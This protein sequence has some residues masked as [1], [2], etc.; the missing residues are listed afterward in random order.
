MS[1]LPP[2]REVRERLRTASGV[3]GRWGGWILG[4]VLS[5]GV[6]AADGEIRFSRDILPVLSDA[7]FACHGPDAQSR[8][9]G[10]RLDTAEGVRAPG[11]SGAVVVLP[12]DPGHSELI[13]RIVSQDPDEVMP[14]P[15]SNRRLTPAQ[16]D[17][18]RRWVAQGASWGRHWAYEVP[19]R[20]PVPRIRGGENPVDGFIRARL[21]AEGLAP[22]P[23]AS[24]EV[25]MRRVTLDLTGV[26][27]TPAERTAFLRDDVPGAYE[28]LVD[29]L[30]ASPR[31][32]ERM[33][34]E[35][36][37]A[38]RYA[39]SNGYQG[40]GERTMWPWRDWV[41]SALNR[42]QPYDEFTVWQLAGDLLPGATP[43]QRLATGFL[44]NHMINGEGGRIPEENRIDYL[45][46]QT[47]TVATVWLAATFNCTRCH[48]HKYDPHTQRDYFGLLA[49]FNRT[50][51]DGSGGN[52]Q[53]PPAL[54]VPSPEQ[55]RKRSEAL[56]DLAAATGVTEAY[57]DHRFPRAPGK[58]P[59]DSAAAAGLPETVMAALR[60]RAGD[61]DAG[62]LEVIAGHFRERD[63]EYAATLDRQRRA[64]EIRDA[65]IR[66]IPRVMVMEDVEKPRAT[67]V[68]NRGSYLQ[69]VSEVSLALPKAL[70]TNSAL[71]PSNR[72]AL[73]EWLVSP[74]NPLTA[75]VT[76]NRLWQALFGI[77]LVKTAE[78]F[79]VQGE[80]PLHPQLLDWLAVE[81]VESGWDVKHLV[82]LMVTSAAYRQDS[83]MS[84]A[85]AERDP[86]NRLLARGPRFRMPSWMIRDAALSVSGLLVERVGGPPVKP[87]QP[88]GIWEEA[89][90]G[91]KRYEQDHGEALYRRSLYVF[92]R[93]IVGPTMF[94][95][96]ASRQTCT[97]RTPRTN[98]P[99]HA[100]LTLNDLTYLEAARALA[101]EVLQATASSDGERIRSAFQRVTGRL[102]DDTEVGV[103]TRALARH[104]A[105]YRADPAAA[106]RLLSAG[107]S[108]RDP[109][110]DSQDQAAWMLLCS[111]ILNLDEALTRE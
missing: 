59:A 62:K 61:R 76:V 45:F 107:E 105:T 23:E 101:S 26:P 56:E 73:A 31:F 2:S 28:R 54:D 63:P 49:F 1:F 47:E 33:A 44:R 95:D 12:G 57:E 79:G 60:V 82:R 5:L 104:R 55:S 110:S 8:K 88:S 80:R 87:Y 36:L 99:L 64:R 20:P 51:V 103:L 102:P 111:T 68:L 27:P 65:A 58:L 81:W 93:R 13:R 35:W 50:S 10:L 32:G 4:L 46:D 6:V 52:P 75:R 97:V 3:A 30:L 38:A 70:A 37:E 39:D 14:P 48:D 98:V 92:W 94:F 69:P 78:D 21:E 86:E 41:V 67:Y 100:L 96:V 43:E 90:F 18:L 22:S 34:W 74:A 15:K 108:P 89:T 40:D 9:A 71:N 72:L 66:A 17:V 85:L 83:R 106:E 24:R 19:V 53:T 7:C 25:L 29:R 109:H 42:N 91:N 16:V 84:A 11:K 77:G